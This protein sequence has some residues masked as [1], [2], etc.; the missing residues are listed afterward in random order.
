MAEL[1][2]DRKGAPATDRSTNNVYSI[3]PGLPFLRTLAE[4]IL[5]GE[6]G[7]ADLQANPLAFS[8]S[9]IF[10]PT[11]RAARSLGVELLEAAN[12]KFHSRAVILPRIRTIGDLD[13]EENFLGLGAENA[14]GDFDVLGQL[15]D[16][17]KVIDP[18]ER[19]LI[20]ARFTQKW[21]QSM[22]PEVS[23]LLEPEQIALPSSAGDALHMANELARFM[24][25]IETEE[26]D[27][28][29]IKAITG[30]DSFS[31]WW[32]LTLE[33]LHI[34]MEQW[35]Q[36]LA[37]GNMINPAAFRNQV[38]D[39]R[40]KELQRQGGNG[41]VLA[42]GTTGSIPAT[43]RLLA[44]IKNL[45][46]GSIILPGLD[47]DLPDN[48][49]KRFI[50]TDEMSDE[51]VISTHP[52]FGLVR[53]LSKLKTCH[54]EVTPLG[55]QAEQF[56]LRDEII[57]TVLL[58]A[59]DSQL[60]MDLR[61]QY[62]EDAITQA[63]ENVSLIEAT[64]E[65]QEALAV[66]LVLREALDDPQKTAAL[67]TPDRK[68]ARRVSS[69]L[70]RF[71]IQIDDS[72]G[73]ALLISKP[74]SFLRH[75]LRSVFTG[76]DPVSLSSFLKSDLL[77]LGKER[78]SSKSLQELLELLLVRDAI[79]LPNLKDLA[80]ATAKR[81]TE[82][83]TT[84]YS[85]KQL[86]N[87]DDEDWIEIELATKTISETLTPLIALSTASGEINPSE[88]MN[89]LRSCAVKLSSDANRV[90]HLFDDVGGPELSSLLDKHCE[91]R[92]TGFTFKPQEAPSVFDALV[93][94]NRTRKVGR[95]RARLHIYGAL[96]ARLQHSDVLIL[97]G[98]NEGIWPQSPNDDPY[99]NR[100]M[101]SELQL[102]LPERRIGL[103]AH[104]FSQFS[105]ARQVYY[106]RSKRTDDTPAIASRWLQRLKTFLGANQIEVLSNRGTYYLD[107]A[108]QID[109]A[110]HPEPPL[111]RPAPKPPVSTRPKRLSITEIETW[112][113]DPYAIYA[114]HI[115]K[116]RK[117]P[118]LI[119][120]A[121]PALRGT[122]YHN[123]LASFITCWPGPIDDQAKAKLSEIADREFSSH[124]LPAEIKAVWRPRFDAVGE[125]FLNW[126]K[127]R[128]EKIRSSHCEIDL[129]SEIEATGF[130]LHGR[131]DRIDEL[132]DGSLAI[133]DYKTGNTPSVKQ[134]KTL[135]P[136][137]SLEAA[138]A[139]RGK[140]DSISKAPI[141]E[142]LYVRLKAGNE[143]KAD[144][145]SKGKDKHGN[146]CTP[147]ELAEITYEE[148]IQQ[149]IAYQSEDQPYVSLYAPQPNKSYA[150]DYDHLA[151]IREWSLSDTDN[152]E[153]EE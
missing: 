94:G 77:V 78:G 66:A 8:D 151:R 73:E 105:G 145:I 2:T 70:E 109:Q 125:G 124:N 131:A 102:P 62:H 25:Q 60:W 114:K 20:L 50:D 72:A 3:A 106:T 150:G 121:D 9:I 84:T 87:L 115:L 133:I 44:A 128:W 38:I 144:D 21:A 22:S 130:F 95:T 88:L 56:T 34:I 112:I 118:P 1:S 55:A 136:Q 18:I 40:I 99:L 26:A 53:L 113:R 107:L 126:Q 93:A 71:N 32:Q 37:A 96:E 52:Q 30:E 117:L 49:I 129:A 58:P 35:P 6:F 86:R 7:E 132:K 29:S 127:E 139:A 68:L 75:I 135:S 64:S 14:A 141:S 23:R 116:L 100:P 19:Q 83:E 110:R 57:N 111:K 17:L 146:E 92:N 91:D 98:L 24:D 54:A 45:P 43:A 12:R 138:L 81:R 119:R 97:G 76:D 122:I 90:S 61:K 47:K 16:S 4:A 103:A 79:S 13:E 63:F 46:N 65:Y 101:R 152:G 85:P 148:L 120:E 11:R 33:F 36:F 39:F 74:A 69:E 15:P 80:S 41:F 153:G 123:T 67:V 82:I 142:L 48:I 89:A 5:D 140:A 59:E 31:G 137:L 149:I 104:D 134:A 27:W 108:K 143:F 28:Q 10:L 147:G 42:A 51:G